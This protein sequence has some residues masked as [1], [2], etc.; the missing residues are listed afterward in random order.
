MEKDRS[1]ICKI[2]SNMLDNPDD[3]DIYPTGKCYDELEKYIEKRVFETVGWTYDHACR[4]ADDGVDI[5]TIEVPKFL[6]K[7]IKDFN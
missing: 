5:R 2:I 7:Y 4:L 6:E 3:C 1:E